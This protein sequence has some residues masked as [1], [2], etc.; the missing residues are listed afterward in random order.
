MGAPLLLLLQLHRLTRTPPGRQRPVH[1]HFLLDIALQLAAGEVRD[2]DGG[3]RKAAAGRSPS[4]SG[5]LGPGIGG[6]SIGRIWLGNVTGVRQR[7]RICRAA[8]RPGSPQASPLGRSFASL[9]DQPELLA[10]GSGLWLAEAGESLEHRVGIGRPWPAGP[11]FYELARPRQEGAPVV[12]AQPGPCR[13]RQPVEVVAD[14]L[15]RSGLHAQMIP[16]LS[17]VVEPAREV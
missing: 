2:V 17:D 8:P 1:F 14:E 13:N 9:G 12:R 5:G 11:A 6:R 10:F 16:L 3:A 7:F 4:G 15:L